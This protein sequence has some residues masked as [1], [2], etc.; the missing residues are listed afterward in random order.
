MKNSNAS[1]LYMFACCDNL[2]KVKINKDSYDK[3]K[4]ELNIQTKVIYA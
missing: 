1:I 4:N 2:E 3:I